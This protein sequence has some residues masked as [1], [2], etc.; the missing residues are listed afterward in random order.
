MQFYSYS[1]IKNKTYNVIKNYYIYIK[2]KR[3]E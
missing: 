1:F 3:Y 2:I